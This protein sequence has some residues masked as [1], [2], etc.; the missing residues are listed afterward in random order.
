[1]GLFQKGLTFTPQILILTHQEQTAFENIVG[2]GEIARNEQSLLFP[3]CFLLYQIPESAFVHIFDIISLYAVELEE[4][5][6]G[7]S[8]KGLKILCSLC[9]VTEIHSLT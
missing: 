9:H 2:K 7:I 1:M 4:F 5:K 8:V 6:I 3:Q